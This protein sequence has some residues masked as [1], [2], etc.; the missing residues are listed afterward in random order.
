MSRTEQPDPI[1]HQPLRLAIVSFL[2]QVK[3]ADFNEIREKTHSTA[4]NLSVQITRLKDAGYIS[5]EKSYRDNYPL[6]RCSMTDAGLE[7]WKVY[8]AALMEYLQGK[9]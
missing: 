2:V 6:T 7:A 8:C 5:V 1:L 4:G 9:K 3:Y